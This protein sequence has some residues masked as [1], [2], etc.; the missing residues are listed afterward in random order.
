MRLTIVV[1]TMRTDVTTFYCDQ[2]EGIIGPGIELEL[3]QSFAENV[4]LW[5]HRNKCQ[6][7][8]FFKSKSKF[9]SIE[10]V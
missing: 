3:S 4:N 10:P 8:T 5:I 2:R 6:M 1:W 9:S 7:L